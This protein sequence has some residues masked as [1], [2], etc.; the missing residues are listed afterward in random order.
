M[1]E[2][3]IESSPSQGTK[4]TVRIFGKAKP[5]HV[6]QALQDGAQKRVA[7]ST[8]GRGWGGVLPSDRSTEQR[9]VECAYFVRPCLGERV[10]GDG[11][12]LDRRGDVVF[13][14]LLDALGHGQGAHEIAAT[15]R[16]HLRD[17]WSK[18]L[19]ATAEGLDQ[20]LR[21][22][23]GAAGG[24]AT[25]NT[26]TRELRYVGIGN[27]ILRPMGSRDVRF[28]YAEGT[29]GGRMR[30]PREQAMRME[31]GE[32]ALMFSDGVS[33]RLREEDY[34]QLR[35]EKLQTVARTIVERFGK[36]H[37]DATCIALRCLR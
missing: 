3:E 24:L 35:Y 27:V 14:A 18:D 37:D 30:K 13:I 26:Q 10:S 2:F 33:E 6:S 4:V 31:T 7:R 1:D 36:T 15:A 17:A 34:P 19:V 5:T 20:R 11:V 22:T 25:F 32:V 8:G 28:Q 12:L 16:R 9:D 21:G 29:L 23:G